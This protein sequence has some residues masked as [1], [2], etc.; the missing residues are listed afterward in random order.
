MFLNSD[1][2]II[3]SKEDSLFLSSAQNVHIGAKNTLTISTEKETIIESSNV[4]LGKQAKETA[5]SYIVGADVQQGMVL[6]ENL[7]E[8]LAE[9]ID[10]LVSSNGHCQGAPIP[11]G[12]ENGPPGSLVPKLIKLKNLIIKDSNDIVSTKHFIEDNRER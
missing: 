6:G 4:Y 5:P 1:R 12:A 8:W 9:L 2:I 7:R 3:N 10:L 11:L